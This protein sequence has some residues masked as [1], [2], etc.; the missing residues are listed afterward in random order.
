VIDARK[1]LAALPP[2]TSIVVAIEHVWYEDQSTKA[3]SV[4]G[5]PLSRD[6]I[7]P[8]DAKRYT[9]VFDDKGNRVPSSALEEAWW[10][11]KVERADD[12]LEVC[13]EDVPPYGEWVKWGR[14][15]RR[16]NWTDLCFKVHWNSDKAMYTL[17][18]PLSATNNIY[19]FETDREFAP[20]LHVYQPGLR[21]WQ[22]LNEACGCELVITWYVCRC[23]PSP[24]TKFNSVQWLDPTRVSGLEKAY[25]DLYP[26]TRVSRV[27]VYV[28]PDTVRP[29]DKVAVTAKIVYNHPVG[30][31]YENAPG[32]AEHVTVRL[33]VNGREL[34]KK[35]PKIYEGE[36]MFEEYRLGNLEGLELSGPLVFAEKGNYKVEVEAY[37]D[38]DALAG[39]RVSGYT[40]VTVSEEAPPPQEGQPPEGQP[41]GEQPPEGQP[42][43]GGPVETVTWSS[44]P[45]G[46]DVR[47]LLR[48]AGIVGGVA[49]L[50]LLYRE[51]RRG[52]KK[53]KEEW[54]KRGLI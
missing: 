28:E 44:Q 52:E 12:G 43:E 13:W 19:L 54:K 31:G 50:L 8:F 15:G 27:E 24:G 18:L 49:T 9:L 36:V 20:R 51:A 11:F 47:E 5:V 7:P 48:W 14:E 17:E 38:T 45:G 37:T 40:Y 3:V 29:G 53:I 42:P 6:G 23:P 10:P 35:N 22:V 16:I 34:L 25:F 4:L 32:G 21:G 39:R 26:A 1:V 33:L 41:P 2:D 46:L 30:R